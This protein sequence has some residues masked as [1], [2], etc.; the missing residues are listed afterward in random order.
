[1]VVCPAPAGTQHGNRITA[2]RWAAILRR[3]GHRA[4]IVDRFEDQPA[5]L[6]IA[7]HAR[8]SAASVEAF[9]RMR[10]ELPIVVAL[11]GTDLYRDLAGS[12]RARRTLQLARR[13]IVLQSLAVRELPPPLRRKARVVHQ[14]APGARPR[15]GPKGTFDVAVI[16]HLRPV[17]DPMRTALAA[18]RLPAASC[19]RVLHFGRAMT[20]GL[21]RRAQIETARNPR[22]DWYGERPRRETLARLARCRLLVLSSRLEGGANVLSEALRAGV[23]VLASRIPG[24]VG[25]LGEDYPGLFTVGDT[26]ALARLLDKSERDPRFYAT[27]R[28][29]CRR[30]AALF[31]PIRERAAW[32]RLLRELSAG[33]RYGVGFARS[34]KS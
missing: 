7:L 1:M 23:P 29:H 16:G 2:R 26:G 31:S 15:P 32:K 34:L 30:R 9:H 11:T 20:A 28:R 10:P 5:D 27:L 24:S 4:A 8:K 25:I 17:K 19:V 33:R 14:S 22:Y 12:A 13:L 6:L 3:L 21:A 18:R